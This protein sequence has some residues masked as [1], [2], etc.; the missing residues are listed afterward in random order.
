[1]PEPIVP[2][3]ITPT[4]RTSRGVASASGILATARSAKK[5]WTRPARC[6]LSRHSRKRRRSSAIPSA[7]GKVLAAIASTHLTGEMRCGFR[8]PPPPSPPRWRHH[9]AGSRSRPPGASAACRPAPPAR[10]RA[11]PRA[12][13]PPPAVDQP[14]RQRLLPRH[15]PAGG[16]ELDRGGDAG[17]ARRALRAARAGQEAERDL[18]Q[19][20]AQSF[21]TDARVAGERDLKPAAQ[22]DPVQH[23]DDGLG[24]R[25]DPVHHLGQDRLLRRTAELADVRARD[26]GAALAVEG[27]DLHRLVRIRG[28]QAVD[29]PPPQ[30]VRG[31][32]H[33][34]VVAARSGRRAPA[35]PR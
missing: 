10:P 30:R 27:D 11:R 33:R 15:V 21:Q 20:D 12:A 5:A 19:P 17:K 23:R 28:G 13:R 6:G 24:G 3:P 35:S 29:Q 18:R 22:S 26:E 4:L 9:R 7:I 16:D 8:P 34:R 25:L 2:P 31:G 14:Q 32:V 1:M